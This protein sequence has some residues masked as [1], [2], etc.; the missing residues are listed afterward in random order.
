[1]KCYLSVVTDNKEDSYWHR[2]KYGGGDFLV[3]KRSA[4]YSIIIE[5]ETNNP[6]NCFV[7]YGSNKPIYNDLINSRK[8]IRIKEINGK[9]LCFGP[10]ED[11]QIVIGATFLPI[12]YEIEKY[13]QYISSIRNINSRSEY[14]HKYN[15]MYD[16]HI[17][18]EYKK[19]EESIVSEM[20]QSCIEILTV[21]NERIY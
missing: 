14:F 13:K 16:I 8:I 7:N 11:T 20:S 1:M 3:V 9:R 21:L 6:M 15:K 10:D 4:Y 2:A 19:P 12:N 5:N 17:H 18:D